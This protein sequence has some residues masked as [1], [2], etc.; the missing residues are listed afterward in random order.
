VHS[1]GAVEAHKIGHWRGNKSAAARHFHVDIR[2][3]DNG[4]SESVYNLAVNTRIVIAL[5]FNDLE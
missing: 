5:F 2:I 4:A 3:G 1:I